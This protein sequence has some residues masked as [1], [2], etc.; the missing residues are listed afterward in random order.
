MGAIVLAVSLLIAP[1]SARAAE[2][3]LNGGFEA[4]LAGWTVVDQAGGS[5]SWFSQTGTL[6]PLNGFTVSAPPEGFLAAMTDQFGPG[7]HVMYQDFVVP[8][9]VT[10][11]SLDFQYYIQNQ[12][13]VFFTPDTLDYTVSPNQQARVD[14]ITT[15]ADPFS[16]AVADVLLNLYQTQVGDPATSGYTLISTILTAFLQAHEGETLRLRFAEVDNQLFFLNGVDAVSLDVTAVPEPA[17]LALLGIGLAGAAWRR[18][19]SA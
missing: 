8:T 15:T 5:G 11:A 13:D 16:V 18:R 10:S 6:S 7:S 19:R 12:A 14:I 1:A 2:L 4:G 9:G 17:T 3:L